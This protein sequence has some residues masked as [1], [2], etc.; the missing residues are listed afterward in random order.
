[1]K[2]DARV[3]DHRGLVVSATARSWLAS[4]GVLAGVVHLAMV[5]SHWG[6]WRAEGVAFAVVGWVQ[7]ALAAACW[8]S[9]TRRVL[10]ATA[11]VNLA[12]V[13]AWLVTRTSGSPWGPHAWHAESVSVID[14]AVVA[15]EVVL[16]LLCAAVLVV[17]RTRS[18]DAR[19]VLAPR[20]TV[21]A[22]AVAVL[23]TALLAPPSA[24]N[25]AHDAR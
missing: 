14:G 5:P 16:F 15:A 8:L 9:P 4:L 24:R 13:S 23:T 21:P 6:E 3:E 10:V 11:F 22:A 1:M 7:L 12:S 20:F 19:R 2:M 17:P 25:H 18:S